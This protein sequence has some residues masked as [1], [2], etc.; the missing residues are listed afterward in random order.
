MLTMLICGE[1]TCSLGHGY[2][3][4]RKPLVNTY[5]FFPRRSFELQEPHEADMNP[6]G[7]V[8]VVRDTATVAADSR[9]GSSQTGS[10][11]Q[12]LMFPQVR[13]E[14]TAGGVENPAITDIQR[15]EGEWTR[16]HSLTKTLWVQCIK[17]HLLVIIQTDLYIREKS[18]ST[19]ISF[20]LSLSCRL[21]LKKIQHLTLPGGATWGRQASTAVSHIDV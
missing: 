13:L 2:F 10:D 14:E 18:Q 15:D 12:V 20:C 6:A 5:P 1:A 16:S 21:C 17:H 19:F 4:R 7:L 9:A 8:R 3:L 11:P